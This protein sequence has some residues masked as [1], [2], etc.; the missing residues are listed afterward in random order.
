[1]RI[2][3]PVFGLGLLEAVPEQTILATAEQQRVG[4]NGRPNYVWDA[5]G[6]RTTLGRF[7]WKAN[8]PSIKQQIAAAALGDMGLTSPLYREQN[9]PSVQHLCS[10]QTPGNDPELVTTD[11]IEL[12]FWT[13]GLGVPARRNLGDPRVQRGAA[14]FKEARCAVCHVPEMKTGEKF[15]AAAP[16]QSDLHYTTCCCTTWAGIGRQPARF[17][18]RR[19]RLAHT[20]ALGDRLVGTVNGSTAFLHDVGT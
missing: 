2:A 13:L 7:G 3:Q 17:S 5:I 19:A 14:M 20:A 1:M 6:K 15:R 10:M 9:C 16:R 12:E 8:Q 11:W 18:S 4:F